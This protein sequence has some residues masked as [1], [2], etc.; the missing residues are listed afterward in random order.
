MSGDFVCTSANDGTTY[1][2]PVSA[3]GHTF[4]QEQNLNKFVIDNN[5]DFYI[6]KSVDSQEICDKIR[7][8][9]LDFVS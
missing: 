1:F 8:A 7:E 2:R 5:E 9:D 6:V 4:W 3:R